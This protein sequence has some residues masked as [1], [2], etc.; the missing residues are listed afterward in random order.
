MQAKSRK[1]YY[2]ASIADSEA[3]ENS[4]SDWSVERHWSLNTS[5]LETSSLLTQHCCSKGATISYC[6]SEFLISSMQSEQ[7]SPPV[8]QARPPQRQ[9]SGAGVSQVGPW[10]KSLGWRFA[11]RK[12]FG[13]CAC[14][15]TEGMNLQ[16]PKKTSIRSSGA[17]KG[18]YR[19]VPN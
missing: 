6:L 9:Q 4:V 5:S 14:G 17:R 19:A 16:S 2:I 8:L 15:W 11:C 1:F 18:L 10:W 13:E 7:Q 3:S 12:F